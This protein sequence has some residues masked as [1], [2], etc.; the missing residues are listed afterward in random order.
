MKN[1]L[2]ISLLMAVWGSS[3]SAATISTDTTWANRTAILNQTDGFVEITSGATLTAN[4]RVDNDGGIGDAGRVILNSGNFTSTVDYKLPD[5]NSGNP[6]YLGILYGTF[7]A[8]QFESFGL[9]RDAA[10]EIGANGT[11][12]IKTQ[13]SAVT[14]NDGNRYNVGNLILEG[15]LYASEGL[16]LDVQ[17]LGGGAVQ[18]SAQGPG[19]EVPTVGFASVISLG[20]ESSDTSI[21]PVTLAYPEGEVVEVDYTVTG[22]TAARNSDYTLADGTLTL[23][24]TQTTRDIV[25]AIDDDAISEG[26]E[27]VQITLF[28]PVNAI[29]GTNQHTFTI[30]DDDPFVISS[31]ET[32]S[33]RTAILDQ[34][35]G[36]VEIVAGGSVTADARVDHDGG[37]GD[38]GRVIL[39]GGNFTSTVDYKFPDN[40]TG[41][42]AF[43]V[44]YDGTFTAYQFESFGLAR[45]ATIEIGANGTF[46][47]ET[48][49]SAVTENDGNR[50]NIGNL[51]LEGAIYA[52]SGLDLVVD[53]LGGGAVQITAAAK[54]PTKVDIEYLAGTNEI[55]LDW[56]GTGF[57][58]SL[59]YIVETSLDLQP[60]NWTN[61]ASAVGL[62]EF[63]E[64]MASRA[65]YRVRIQVP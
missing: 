32:W 7:T 40:N 9:A 64:T 22:G 1:L 36:Y 13:Y 51:I 30:D 44:M 55:R 10:I 45:D 33:D 28:N 8:N 41:N 17:D 58:P 20:L 46:I 29:L 27:T 21:I 53:D 60:G 11:F 2:I 34:A 5:N 18:I 61:V 37:I 52:S 35:E 56:S 62:R 23:S 26:A 48:Q 54:L 31:Q 47:V 43:I 57:N 38:A 14:E 50:Y 59:T 6:A 3:T 39:N 65:F 15:S 24:A 19:P 25:I 63:T 12:V 4:A 49:Y 42:P 16:T